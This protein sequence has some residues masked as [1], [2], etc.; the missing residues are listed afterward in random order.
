MPQKALQFTS[1][2][3]G[4]ALVLEKVQHMRTRTYGPKGGRSARADAGRSFRDV[5]AGDIR[6]IRSIVGPKY[7]Q[8]LRQLLGY[9]R[10]NFPDLMKRP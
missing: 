6:D 4:G 3:E 5:L 9:Y 2:N 10:E 7:D 8:G 1:A